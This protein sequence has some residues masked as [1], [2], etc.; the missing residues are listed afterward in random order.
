MGVRRLYNI[1]IGRLGTGDAGNTLANAR[2]DGKL[3]KARIIE[4][5]DL[6]SLYRVFMLTVVLGVLNPYAAEELP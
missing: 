4:R 3:L 1:D 6:S 5:E 2:V